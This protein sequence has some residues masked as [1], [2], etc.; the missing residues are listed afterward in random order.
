MSPP[1]V[2][3]ARKGSDEGGHHALQP[4]YARS[5]RGSSR[6]QQQ[7]VLDPSQFVDHRYPLTSGEVAELTRLSERQVRY[8]ADRGLIPHWRRGR[9]RLFESVGLIAAFSITNASQ[10]ELQFYRGVMEEPL[11]KLAA[12][13]GILSSLLASRLEDVEPSQ[14]KALAEPLAE[15]SRR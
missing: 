14:A 1:P 2:N 3:P 8:W 10:H 13:L 15:L 11:E 7:I 9:R 4:V 12:K 6:G 5:G